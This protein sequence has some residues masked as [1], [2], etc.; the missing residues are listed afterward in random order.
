M[1]QYRRVW[2]VNAVAL[3]LPWSQNSYNISSTH[4]HYHHSVQINTLLVEE[5][6]IMTWMG[7]HCHSSPTFRTNALRAFN[8]GCPSINV[9]DWVTLPPPNWCIITKRPQ[10]VWCFTDNCI[11]CYSSYVCL[12]SYLHANILGATYP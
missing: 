1:R 11:I 6:V 4:H 5:V 9:S 8:C 10:M 2:L 12:P 3:L 7:Q